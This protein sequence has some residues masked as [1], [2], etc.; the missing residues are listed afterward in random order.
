MINKFLIS[1]NLGLSL[2]VLL[3]GICFGWGDPSICASWPN[4]HLADDGRHC[5]CDAGY[6]DNGNGCSPASSGDGDSGSS[7]DD[8]YDSAAVERARQA[9]AERQRQLEEQR[10]EAQRR[11]VAEERR[12]QEE[13]IRQRDDAARSLKG[14]SHRDPDLKGT[15][16]NSASL[17]LKGV[18]GKDAGLQARPSG[19]QPSVGSAFQQLSQISCAGS[20][21]DQGV[22]TFVQNP[23]PTGASLEELRYVEAQAIIAYDGGQVEVE[24]DRTGERLKFKKTNPL[25]DRDTY[26]GLLKGIEKLAAIRVAFETQLVDVRRKARASAREEAKWTAE[27]QKF[28]LL[29]PAERQAPGKAQEKDRISTLLEQAR[30]KNQEAQKNKEEAEDKEKGLEEE[31]T[32]LAQR[33]QGVEPKKEGDGARK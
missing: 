6:V 26:L 23:R 17:G 10:R 13:W 8:G 25:P 28:E 2:L 31:M 32:Q 12:L 33:L 29:P 20:I 3:P 4:S 9:A 16:G 5:V 18:E 27:L 14:V 7:D 22:Q 15:G 1:R 11:R 30:A 19:P 21:A 24:C